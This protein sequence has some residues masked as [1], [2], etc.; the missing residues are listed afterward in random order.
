MIGSYRPRR[1]ALIE[2]CFRHGPL[3]LCRC[4]R[5][6]EG[7]CDFFDGE[8]REEPQLDDIALPRVEYPQFVE[9]FVEGEDIDAGSLSPHRAISETDSRDPTPTLACSLP[10]SVVDENLPHQPGRH[11][12][13]V[14]AV[15]ERHLVQID[16]SQ[17]HLVH[18]GRCLQRV[19][20]RLPAGGGRS[21]RGA[22]RRRRVAPAARAP[23]RLRA[24]NREAGW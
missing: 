15:V 16:E 17:I 24:A 18:E 5:Y 12:K 23:R 3:A 21:R 9:R 19:A 14:C 6:L 11:G 2:P 20:W 13:E 8:P 1:Q 10:A 22:A 4:P 7:L